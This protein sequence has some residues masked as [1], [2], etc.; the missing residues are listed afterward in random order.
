MGNFLFLGTGNGAARRRLIT[1]FLCLLLGA[2]AL[3]GGDGDWAD[4]VFGDG[5]RVLEGETCITEDANLLFRNGFSSENQNLSASLPPL[6]TVGLKKECILLCGNG[7]LTVEAAANRVAFQVVGDHG[8]GPIPCAIR[9]C[10]SPISLL[11]EP[12][13]DFEEMQY[14]GYGNRI[15]LSHSLDITYH[16]GDGEPS[17]EVGT[18][19]CGNFFTTLNL[20][21]GSVGA[22][23]GFSGVISE[24]GTVN[25]HGHWELPDGIH[26]C[27]RLCIAGDGHLDLGDGKV[28]AQNIC[29]SVDSTRET[30]YLHC[31]GFSRKIMVEVI[32]DGFAM[33]NPDEQSYLL[34][35]GLR[36]GKKSSKQL[37]QLNG[38][39]R[40]TSDGSCLYAVLDCD[41]SVGPD[42]PRNSYYF[43][44]QP[45]GIARPL[46]LPLDPEAVVLSF[47][48]EV[49]GETMA[50]AKNFLAQNEAKTL[51]L[52]RG[53]CDGRLFGIGCTGDDPFVSILAAH[54][55]RENGG[56]PDCRTT[57]Y[58]IV[59]G[60]DRRRDLS[61]NGMAFLRGGVF[62]GFV[63]GN[64]K[65]A[66]VFLGD[67][68]R[69][70]QR[71]GLLGIFGA[72]ERSD[73]Q[74]RKTNV[75]ASLSGGHTRNELRDADYRCKFNSWDIS[76]D[77]SYIR[78]LY[79]RNGWQVGPWVGATYHRIRQN[80]HEDSEAQRV[81]AVSADLFHTT[82]GLAAEREGTVK[83]SGNRPLSAYLRAAWCCQTKRSMGSVPPVEPQPP[84][85]EYGDRHSALIVLGFRQKLNAH[86]EIG[87]SWNGDFSKNYGL[88]KVTIGA[89]YT[90]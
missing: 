59:G 83:I 39:Y 45:G 22:P 80:S 28:R 75:E 13:F 12:D 73:G 54:G 19:I 38:G 11:W 1:G 51:E 42:S 61:P 7:G 34:V 18:A 49:D 9:V 57:F 15:D 5:F 10:G 23:N 77:C 26:R 52:A 32:F 31:G 33:E 62:A 88:N 3:R 90:F 46:P 40:L 30:A 44:L 74:S 85:N 68:R 86:W 79:V 17:E 35:D 89:G 41:P 21:G 69:L 20:R 60:A 58:G 25:V 29:F 81:S 55:K 84:N 48:L 37:C 56:E 16:T 24:V 66:D 87:G 36:N 27:Q 82:L 67:I 63:R 70:E 64:V 6:D 2:P 72:F 4:D 53:G 65:Y 47:E 78:S 8:D 14:F 71:T 43:G 76:L 50:A